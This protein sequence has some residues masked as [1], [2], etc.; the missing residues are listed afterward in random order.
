MTHFPVAHVGWGGVG[1]DFVGGLGVRLPRPV[2]RTLRQAE[3]EI[4]GVQTVDAYHTT[5]ER[6]V[7][8]TTTAEVEVAVVEGILDDEVDVG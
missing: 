7:M 8:L 6:G 5:G 1:D 4:D 2:V 3:A